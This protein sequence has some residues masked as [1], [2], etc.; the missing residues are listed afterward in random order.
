MVDI[1]IGVLV[2]WRTAVERLAIEEVDDVKEIFFKRS[3][4]CRPI[5][6]GEPLNLPLLHSY[7]HTWL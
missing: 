3:F 6:S 7:L 1:C 5:K 2:A 4:S